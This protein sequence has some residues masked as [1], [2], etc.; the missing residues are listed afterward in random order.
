MINFFMEW[1][2]FALELANYVE[3]LSRI[4][5]T[6]I[7]KQCKTYKKSLCVNPTP[8]LEGVS[9]F[10]LP[11]FKWKTEMNKLRNMGC[12]IIP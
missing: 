10:K 5:I 3:I 4:C 8:G 1:S 6:M 11:E 2:G 9:S 12:R 7:I